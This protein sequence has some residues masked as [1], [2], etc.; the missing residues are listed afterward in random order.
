M[1]L[2]STIM[3]VLNVPVDQSES[4]KTLGDSLAKVFNVKEQAPSIKHL[5]LEQSFVT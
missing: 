1:M 5:L 4:E 3:C 2:Q